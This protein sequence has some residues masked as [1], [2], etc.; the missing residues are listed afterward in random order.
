MQT[1]R[2]LISNDEMEGSRINRAAK[3]SQSV[4]TYYKTEREGEWWQREVK[5]NLSI[6]SKRNRN[7]SLKII[8]EVLKSIIYRSITLCY[9]T[10]K[11]KKKILIDPDLENY[12]W[13]NKNSIW[14]S[15]KVNLRFSILT[16]DRYRVSR[17]KN[18]S[19]Y[20]STVETIL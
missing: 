12:L 20:N 15:T 3:I 10:K 13:A 9:S 19:L 7:T 4:Q 14:Y 6:S 8:R 17:E 11:K 16:I 1:Y 5:K 18:N 2:Q